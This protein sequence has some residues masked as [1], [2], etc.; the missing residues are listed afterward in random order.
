MH[1]ETVTAVTE[2]LHE[3]FQR[4]VPQLSAHK[5]PP[6]KQELDELIKSES[7]ILLL[8]RDP[9]G[10]APIAGALCLTVYRV[11][12]G[13]RSIVEDVIVDE[14]MR[15]RGIG[16]ALVR[17]AIDLARQAGAESVSLTS[18]PQRKAANKLY[19]SIGFQLRQTNPYYY[20]LK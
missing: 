15:R 19:Q 16:E 13:L 11:P 4:L 8:A 2:E 6:T 14:T 12:T 1:I 10:T 20:R 5:V 9:D 17:K 3:A 18:N 7:S